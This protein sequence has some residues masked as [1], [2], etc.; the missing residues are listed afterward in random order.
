MAA[1]YPWVPASNVVYTLGRRL[2]NRFAPHTRNKF[3]RPCLDGT[4]SEELLLYG[5]RAQSDAF[6]C[7]EGLFDRRTQ[8]YVRNEQKRYALI[9]T[10]FDFKH[11]K[12]RLW[13]ERDAKFVITS[14]EGGFDK[15]EERIGD[16][17]YFTRV[18]PGGIPTSLGFIENGLARLTSF[19]GA[20]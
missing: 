4:L 13:A 18:V 12:A 16:Y 6:R 7:M 5:K 9:G 10:K 20:H 11:T 15:G 1:L 14:R 3:P 19:G 8:S 17:V 2:V